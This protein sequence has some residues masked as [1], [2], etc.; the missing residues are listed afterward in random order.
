MDIARWVAQVVVADIK[1]REKKSRVLTHTHP[2]T[3]SRYN[4]PPER[5]RFTSVR[6]SDRRSFRWLH[7]KDDDHKMSC[8]CWN[9]V[10]V[11]ILSWKSMMPLRNNSYKSAGWKDWKIPINVS[12]GWWQGGASGSE[13]GHIQGGLAFLLGNIEKLPTLKMQWDDKWT[14]DWLDDQLLQK[15]LLDTHSSFQWSNVYRVKTVFCDIWLV[16]KNR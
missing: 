4:L 6:A 14:M 5:A 11:S 1:R 12:L 13:L 10:F 2:H 16:N 3:H 15:Q 7:M 8:L 9:K